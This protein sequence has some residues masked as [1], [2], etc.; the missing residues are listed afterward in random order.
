M[1]RRDKAI[2]WIVMPLL[3]VAV[4]IV[5]TFHILSMDAPLPDD[6]DLL[7]RREPLPAEQNAFDLFNQAYE[8]LEEDLTDEQRQALFEMGYG[9][10]YDAA[11][12]EEVLET[13]E[14]GLRLWRKGLK[15][16]GLQ[17]PPIEGIGTLMPYLSGWMNLNELADLRALHLHRQGRHAEALEAAVR[18]VRFGRMVMGAEA[19]L[20]GYLVGVTVEGMGLARIRRMLPESRLSREVL[21]RAVEALRPKEP[22][23]TPYAEAMRVEYVCDARLVE[24][25]KNGVPFG[26]DAEIEGYEPG[27]RVSD[28]LFQ[29]NRTKRAFARYL[30]P[31]I[32]EAS[33]PLAE[34]RLPKQP[35]LPGIPALAWL[36]V[37]GNVV[38]EILP[39][40]M[41]HGLEG[42]FKQKC[43]RQVLITATRLLLALKAYKMETGRLPERLDVLVPACIDAVPRD[44]F[45][46]DPFRYDRE[47]GIIYS[48]GENLVDDGGTGRPDDEEEGGPVPPPD[49]VFRIRF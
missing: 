2:V 7:P 23:G 20:V 3:A 1:T 5:A 27:G 49:C 45:D 9:E 17:V 8:R 41:L 21:A 38:G 26:E 33:E 16:P 30:R 35:P 25:L 22:V 13:A 39:A 47:E 12:A 14:E 48:V 6:A 46:G 31:M 24:D 29:V 19:G 28:F 44:G 40:L 32:L 15:R 43:R 18:I 10:Q 42:G 34:A 36:C 11:K 37:K 4:G